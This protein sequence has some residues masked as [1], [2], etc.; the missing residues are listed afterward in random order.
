VPLAYA[1][2]Q[3]TWWLEAVAPGQWDVVEVRESGQVVGRMPFVY[4]RRLGLNALTQ[5]PLTPYLGPW[6]RQLDGKD[7]R[8]CARERHILD[9]LLAALP[10]H[11]V[12]IQSFHP[13][14]QD[15]LPLFWQGFQQTTLYTY[16]L[17]APDDRQR[18]WEGLQES[19]RRQ[20]R[21]A[22][23]QLTVTSGDDLDLFL[24]LHRHTF[25]RQG[26]ELPYPEAVVRRLDA[27]CAA[28]EQRQILFAA[29]S[30]ATC[31]AAIYT[32]WDDT[33]A[34]YLMG[35]SDPGLRSSGAMSLLM[36]AAIE[37]ANKIGRSFDFEGSMIQSVER[38]FRCFGGRQTPYFH[39]SG[40]R[41]W[42]GRLALSGIGLLRG[43][44]LAEHRAE[45]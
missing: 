16:L 11:D 2:F 10:R 41:S 36:W 15:W 21:K 18:L 3:E 24:T 7:A 31:H 37:Y 43:W 26:R 38:F 1:L 30:R 8:R 42:R 44:G 22:E 28:R 34:Y 23:R 5:P 35:G 32:V 9:Q 17:H 33:T 40:A 39:I 14:V 25:G 45:Q 12:F 13:A 6:L 20:I 27:C 19:T 29:D 4:R